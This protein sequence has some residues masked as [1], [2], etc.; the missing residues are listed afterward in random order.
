MFR[1]LVSPNV[2]LQPR[3]VKGTCT[4]GDV[5]ELTLQLRGNLSPAVF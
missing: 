1:I 2:C 5:A 3:K 4:G